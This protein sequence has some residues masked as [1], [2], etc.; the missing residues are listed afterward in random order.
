MRMG[1]GGRQHAGAHPPQESSHRA[2]QGARHKLVRASD[3]PIQAF[4]SV[5][6]CV[7]STQICVKTA[8][9]CGQ[10]AQD[11]AY[12]AQ[13]LSRRITSADL[14]AVG[15]VD[16]HRLRN[17]LKDLPEFAARPANE[18]VAIEYTRHDLAV[19][20]VLCELERMGLRKD[21]IA[22]WVTPIQQALSGPR[23]MNAP[24]LLLTSEPAQASLGDEHSLLRA[25]MVVDLDK[26]L[27]LV[28]TH[29]AGVDGGRESQRDLE[30]GPVSVGRTTP[31]TDQPRA[32]RHG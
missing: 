15:R 21:A 31:S 7:N 4:R 32:R 24:Q 27:R 19:V 10:N 8:H 18:R 6:I 17:L 12:D 9:S 13:M 23:S 30:F 22:R 1:S 25:G 20:A 28:D 16:R 29:C 2:S 11:C 14:A 3:R 26:I 5:S